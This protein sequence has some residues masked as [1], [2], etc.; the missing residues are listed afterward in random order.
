M[1]ATAETIQTSYIPINANPEIAIARQYGR[2]E[3][4][5]TMEANRQTLLDGDFEEVP[6]PVDALGTAR[7]VREAEELYCIGSP[8]WQ[9]CFQGLVLDCSRLYGEAFRVNTWEYFEPIKLTFVDQTEE[10]YSH[11]QS[12]KKMTKAGLSPVAHP[13]ERDRRINEHVEE[14]THIAVRSL[15]KLSL[16]Q[17][18]VTEP[19]KIRT[20]S[21]CADWAIEEYENRPKDKPRGGYGGY[22]PQIKK[23]MVRDVVTDM[24][25]NDRFEEQMGLSGIYITHNVIAEALRRRDMTEG[26]ATKT[27]LH[28]NQMQVH[29]DLID[30][31]EL[32]DEVAS[33]QSGQDI[34]LGE[35]LPAGQQ[36]DY[37]HV[38]QEAIERQRARD[39]KAYELAE[40]VM[41]LEKDET[42]RWAATGLVEAEVKRVMLDMAGENNALAADMFD[43]Q[44]EQGLRAVAYLR[45]IGQNEAAGELLAEVS[46]QAP[47]PGYCGAGSCGLESVKLGSKEAK[48]MKEMGL[49]SSNSLKDNERSCRKCGAK[50]VVYALKNKKKGCLDCHATA[51]LK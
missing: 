18:I 7:R 40:F 17:T 35:V 31:V 48:A 8:E 30:F 32:L 43:S 4:E 24:L 39:Y 16:G 42:D 37:E 28:G 47:S 2:W 36:R 34:Y 11:G 38:R 50:K 6:I 44:T 10:F 27:E 49:D 13:E 26:T 14:V 1:A 9:E 15:G 20:I 29:D 12:V 23:L 22:A 46:E 21:E 45:S 5:E 41:A 25:S 3:A 51:D 19:I 33:E